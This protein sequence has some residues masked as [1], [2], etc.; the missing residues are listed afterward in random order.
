MMTDMKKLL[1]F[2]KSKIECAYKK[3]KETIING[4]RH[5]VDL[6]DRIMLVRQLHTVFCSA[7]HKYVMYT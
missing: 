3:V 6:D 4:G 7:T 1:G 5:G 2:P